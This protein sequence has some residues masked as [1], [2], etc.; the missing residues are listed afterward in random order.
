MASCSALGLATLVT[1]GLRYA[2]DR[3]R[4]GVLPAVALT[5]G[6][7]LAFR[8][9]AIVLAIAAVLVLLLLEHVAAKPRTARVAGLPPG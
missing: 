1:L 4:A 8:A 6:Y 2:G 9:G 5:H 7:A 3:I